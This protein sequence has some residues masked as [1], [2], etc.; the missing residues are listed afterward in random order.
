MKGCVRVRLQTIRILE[1]K[2]TNTLDF[3][4]SIIEETLV[5]LST[6]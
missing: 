6:Y 4:Y 3:P 1:K 5:F 2:P